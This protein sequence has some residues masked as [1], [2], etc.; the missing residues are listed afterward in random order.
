VHSAQKNVAFFV[1]SGLEHLLPGDIATIE[2]KGR[3]YEAVFLKYMLGNVAFF[4]NL[5]DLRGAVSLTENEAVQLSLLIETIKKTVTQEEVDVEWAL[6]SNSFFI[7]QSRSITSPL[8]G[9]TSE[10]SNLPDNVFS[11]RGE[12]VSP[13]FANGL[14]EYEG[15]VNNGK[16]VILVLRYIYPK[17]LPSI[18]QAKGVIIESGG[19]LSHGAILCRELRKPCIQIA[20]INKMRDKV[21]G[22]QAY[23]DATTGILGIDI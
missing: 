16:D 11:I 1:R 22:K 7:L 14:I 21:E 3:K 10:Q 2:L 15:E 4:R 9:F 18:Y 12:V 13:G 6:S 5:T 8:T 19:I 20:G 17:H 23:L